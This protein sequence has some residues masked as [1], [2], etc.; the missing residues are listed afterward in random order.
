MAR[1]RLIAIA[2]LCVVAGLLVGRAWWA[3]PL[4]DAPAGAGAEGRAAAP[5]TVPAFTLRDLSG[6]PRSSSEWTDGALLINF[7]ATWC[8]P[9]RK[10]MPLLEQVHAERA[11]RGLTVLG[12][13][14]DRE[15]PVRSFVAETGVSYPILLGEQDAM[16]VAE[17][18]GPDFVALP[19]TVIAAPGGHVLKIHVGEL[20][21]PQLAEILDV[22]DRLAE[23]RI[24]LAEARS[25]LAE[26]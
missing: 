4:P 14:I 11:A 7:W 22:L 19:L 3:P 9:C 23:R 5:E 21:P 17:S 6:A 12:I 15:D 2:G 13:A 18:F 25:S 20:R 8:A 10:E 24:T 1:W 26:G 16:A